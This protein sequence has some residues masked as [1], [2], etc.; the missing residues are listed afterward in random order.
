MHPGA[1]GPSGTAPLGLWRSSRSLSGSA[2]PLLVLKIIDLVVGAVF[3][4][5]DLRCDI[6]AHFVGLVLFFGFMGFAGL[7]GSVFHVAPGFLSGTLDLVDDAGIGETI[8]TGHFP[9]SLLDL[10]YNLICFAF[11]LIRIHNGPL[12]G[13]TTGA[14]LSLLENWP[15]PADQLND[16]HHEC[17]YKQNVYVPGNNVETNQ[18]DE[19]GDEQDD[20]ESPKHPADLLSDLLRLPSQRYG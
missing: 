10:A 20:E 1:I 16:E 2:L 7:V 11:N 3:R 17:Q 5:L 8:V 18:A 6:V 13:P 19:P 12:F 9:G 14:V 4:V 15:S